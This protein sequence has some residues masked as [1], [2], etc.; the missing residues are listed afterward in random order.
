MCVIVYIERLKDRLKKSNNK[1]NNIDDSITIG[2]IKIKKFHTL[3]TL[4]LVDAESFF[5][6]DTAD[7]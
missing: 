2:T 1:K 7:T 4:L 5:T 3:H 6:P